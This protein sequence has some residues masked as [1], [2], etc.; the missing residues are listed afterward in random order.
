MDFGGLNFSLRFGSDTGL[1]F[2]DTESPCLRFHFR[3]ENAFAAVLLQLV[4]SLAGTESF[5]VCSQC[6]RLFESGAGQRR[7]RTGARHYCSERCRKR[8]RSEDVRRFYARNPRKPV[9][10][11]RLGRGA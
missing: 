4:A 8:A 2:D 6:S 1:I 10:D 9:S 5:Y 7:P 11:S 3:I